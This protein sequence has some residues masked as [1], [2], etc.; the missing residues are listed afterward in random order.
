MPEIIVRSRNAAPI[1]GTWSM[2]RT[3]RGRQGLR[4]F[5]IAMR[6]EFNKRKGSECL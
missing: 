6:G 2:S 5:S 1:V 4:P 3:P